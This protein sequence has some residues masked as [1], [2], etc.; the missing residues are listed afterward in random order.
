MD[1]RSNG[2]PADGRAVIGRYHWE[3]TPW[4]PPIERADGPNVVL[5]VLDD[6][7]FAQ[8]GCFG[9]DI[10][11]P[12]LDALAARGLQYTNF[13]TTALCSPTR[14]CLLTG[15]NHHSNGMGR[16][17]ELAMGFPGYH[18]RIPRENGF[19]PEI[20][21]DR[22]WAAW[23]VGK[24]HLTP[25]DEG[26]LGARRDRWPLGRGFERW[27]GFFHGENHQFHPALFHD[28]HHVRPPA[29]PEEG[30]H[31]TADLVDHALAYVTD[32]RAVDD[33]KPFF[34]YLATGA[35]HS[36]HQ[37]PAEWLAEYRG[38]FDRGWDVW[39]DETFARQR[40][41]GLLAET[42]RLSARPD[43]VPP[44]DSLSADEQ[45]VYARFMEAFAAYLSHTDHEL[46][47]LFDTLAAWG[48]LDDTLVLVCSD[49]GAS[50]EGGLI[51]SLNDNKAWNQYP[52]TVAEAV[53][54]IDEIGGPRIHN[55]YPWGWTVAGNTPFRRWKREVHEGG[56]ADP[57]IV[58][59]P[60]GIAARGELR[61][62]FV[63]A[64]DV[65]PTVLQAAGVPAPSTLRG[66]PQSP[67][68][69]TSFAYTFSEPDAP[70]RH[71]TQYF[72]MFGCRALYHHG[73]KAVTWHQIQAPA[74]DF[75]LDQWELYDLTVDPS[76]TNDLS[77][78]EPERLKQMV[79][80]WWIEAATYH[81]LPLD[82]RP[83]SDLVHGRPWSVPE[84]SRYVYRPGMAMVPEEVA[85]NVRNRS[86]TIT[87][88][89]DVPEGGASGILL[90]L[91]SFLGGWSLYLLD[92]VPRYAH[93]LVGSEHHQ[94]IGGSPVPPG[95]HT[96]AYRFTLTGPHRGRGELFVDGTVVGAGEIPRFTPMRFNLTGGGLWCGEGDGLAV[97]DDYQGPFP[98]TGTLHEV[99]VDVEGTA[100]VDPAAEAAHAIATQ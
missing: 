60:N 9:S 99:V 38:R 82:N 97:S 72:E 51:G 81:V 73:W 55:N 29:T 78:S 31:L 93:N 64:I 71:V 58:S 16:I 53:A 4:W 35:C 79:E 65:L 3:S 14:A 84:R 92:G 69:G 75:D 80:R 18:A 90:S 77:G 43:W 67:I 2:G 24:W 95:R 21:T 62:Q 94:V 46:G 5:V 1:E 11:T 26:H 49:N 37:A 91:G 56:V 7:G 10:E 47:R 19:L 27:Y 52:H 20:L 68:E 33:A 25:E 66:V 42:T 40:A 44:W 13:H 6:V 76:E 57:L 22:G 50:S 89:V 88:T 41:R 45:R 30:Y 100:V 61:H 59:W 28:N 85:V 15:R 83:F 48:E 39:R 32:L 98:F 86:H 70:E 54:R 17:M 87:A 63:H 36:P 23:A 12:H 74:Q 8:V 34:L 96:V